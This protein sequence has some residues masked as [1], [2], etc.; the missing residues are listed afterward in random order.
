[1]TRLAATLLLCACAAVVASVS[2]AVLVSSSGDGEDDLLA[3]EKALLRYNGEVNIG[4]EISALFFF[5]KGG[6]SQ[7]RENG[8]N[9]SFAEKKGKEGVLLFCRSRLIRRFLK[10]AE[11]GIGKVR[12]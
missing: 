2:E 7:I 8:K 5:A 1:M 9:H 3:R 10:E 12:N 6:G 11:R 4:E